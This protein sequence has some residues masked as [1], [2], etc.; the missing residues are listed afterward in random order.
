[1]GF[2][3]SVARHFYMRCS[4]TCVWTSIHLHE[5]LYYMHVVLY[6]ITCSAVLIAC[7]SPLYCIVV[8]HYLRVALHS[9]ALKCSITWM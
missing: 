7:S 2:W 5:V 9:T 1:M 8:I 4:I 3:N 6:L